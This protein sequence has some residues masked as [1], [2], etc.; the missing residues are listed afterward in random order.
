MATTAAPRTISGL[1]RAMVQH[2]LLSEYDADALETQAQAE[3]HR[4]CRAGLLSKKM[5][6]AQIAVRRAPSA[7]RCSI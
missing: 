3:Q 5:S 7:R 6:P 4:F 2:G 1:A